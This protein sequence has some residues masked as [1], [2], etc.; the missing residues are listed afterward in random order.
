LRAADH[1]DVLA[2]VVVERFPRESAVERFQ[3]QSRD[4]DQPEP[5]VLGRPPERS[6]SREPDSP[7]TTAM[8]SMSVPDALAA[9]DLLVPGWRSA[10]ASE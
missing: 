5:F 1:E 3:L 9:L 10:R 4:V 7:I 8:V 6:R 2:A